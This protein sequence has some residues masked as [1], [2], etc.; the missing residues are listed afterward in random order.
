MTREQEIAWAAGL[1]EGEGCISFA[2]RN[3][4]I[5]AVFQMAMTDQDV[6]ERFAQIVGVGKVRGPIPKGEGN[7]P[8]WC[9]RAGM[10][11]EIFYLAEL[12]GPFLGVR[13]SAK[14]RECLAAFEE[15]GP[16]RWGGHNRD[17]TH[18]PKGHPYAGNNLLQ[19]VC[20]EGRRRCRECER[21]RSHRQRVAE[22][23]QS[24][25]AVEA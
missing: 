9:Y 11:A 24:D 17:K 7:Q 21:R 6:V 1:F 3:G 4:R 2:P 18:C 20:D 12:L 22:K 8:Q 25:E 16:P 5:R 19:R 15:Q 10:R 14:L 13:R 23:W